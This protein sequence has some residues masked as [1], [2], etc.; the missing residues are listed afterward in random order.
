ADPGAPGDQAQHLRMRPIEDFEIEP[1]ADHPMCREVLVPE[2]G[3]AVASP[4]LFDGCAWIRKDQAA[5]RAAGDGQPEFLDERSGRGQITHGACDSFTFRHS[6]VTIS[7][8]SPWT[9]TKRPRGSRRP[10]YMISSAS[11][12]RR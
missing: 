1:S 11:S 10:G 9:A 6:L 4:D 2:V 7:Q 12:R 3:R 5:A 8:R